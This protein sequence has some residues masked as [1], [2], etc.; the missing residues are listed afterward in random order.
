[1]VGDFSVKADR[2]HNFNPTWNESINEISKI[3][4]LG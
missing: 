4:E 3:M 1:M 2:E